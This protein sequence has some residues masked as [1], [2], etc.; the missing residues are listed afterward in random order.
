MQLI[1]G[2]MAGQQMQTIDEYLPPFQ[3]AER[4]DDYWF[5]AICD[6][7]SAY[8]D[9]WLALSHLVAATINKRAM[10]RLYNS[11]PIRF[12]RSCGVETK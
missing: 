10:L 7:T 8:R 5:L 12:V 4:T 6:R 9:I 1:P 11:T 2:L 3:Q